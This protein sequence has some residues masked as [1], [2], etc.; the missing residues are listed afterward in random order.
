MVEFVSV[1]KGDKAPLSVHRKPLVSNPYL[2]PPSQSAISYANSRK[3][4]FAE[5]DEVRGG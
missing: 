1:G 4:E 3:L 2:A 5:W